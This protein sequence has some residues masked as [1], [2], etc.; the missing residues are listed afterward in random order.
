MVLDRKG[1]MRE[2]ERGR[3]EEIVNVKVNVNGKRNAKS[4]KKLLSRKHR[5]V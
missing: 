2:V 4:G 3:R 1:Q 5:L